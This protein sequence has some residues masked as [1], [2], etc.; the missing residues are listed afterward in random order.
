MDEMLLANRAENTDETSLTHRF[1]SDI[2]V[3]YHVGSLI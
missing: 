2:S 3:D 1:D